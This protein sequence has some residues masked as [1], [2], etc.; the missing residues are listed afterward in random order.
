MIFSIA[1]TEA[2]QFPDTLNGYCH[3]SLHFSAENVNF[4]RVLFKP[5]T[6]R[7]AFSQ[8]QSCLFLSWSRT[9]GNGLDFQDKTA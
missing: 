1:D 4:P 5:L 9:R 7:S 8:T 6:R 3:I 2:V